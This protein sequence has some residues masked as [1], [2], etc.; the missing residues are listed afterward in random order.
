MAS[1]LL[2]WIR[3][4]FACM[5]LFM[6]MTKPATSISHEKEHYW[7]YNT[8]SNKNRWNHS[9]QI[10]SSSLYYWCLWWHFCIQESIKCISYYGNIDLAT[11]KYIWISLHCYQCNHAIWLDLTKQIP[12]VCTEWT[13]PVVNDVQEK[14]AGLGIQFPL[15]WHVTLRI[16]GIC[17]SEVLTLDISFSQVN[18][19]TEP[20]RVE[21]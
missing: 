15:L 3:C 14:L 13:I 4:C 5:W 17:S 11:T 2:N 10:S 6:L 7:A 21:L 9:Y 19:K 12:T 1:I 20:S 18:I 8:H 16:C